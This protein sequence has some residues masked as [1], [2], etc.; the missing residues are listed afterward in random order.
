[1]NN[2]RF[3]FR[4]W[5]SQYSRMHH[6]GD[7]YLE[8][9]YFDGKPWN[10]PA[11]TVMQYTGIKDKNGKEIY[12]GDILSYKQHMHSTSV[13]MDKKDY[14]VYDNAMFCFKSDCGTQSFGG[15][16]SNAG[17]E[18]FEVIGNIFENPELLAEKSLDES[19]NL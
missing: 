12:E 15:G 16:M 8:E 19:Q 4:V 7:W 18:E 2:N 17:R 10:D 6:V 3:N 14:I 11:S 13:T 1:M 5:Y 9:V